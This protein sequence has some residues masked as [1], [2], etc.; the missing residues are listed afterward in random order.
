MAKR[1]TTTIRIDTKTNAAINLLLG[2]LKAKRNRSV[3]QS[4]V[5]WYLVE[6]ARKDIAKRAEQLVAEQPNGDEE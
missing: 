5:V 1:E 6:Q 2:E 3:T 4:D